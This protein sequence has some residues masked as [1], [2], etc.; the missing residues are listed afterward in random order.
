[1]GVAEN[2]LLQPERNDVKDEPYYYVRR[3]CCQKIRSNG[4][5][6]KAEITE[7]WL[8][9]RFILQAQTSVTFRLYT[10]CSGRS[11]RFGIVQCR[12]S[13]LKVIMYPNMDVDQKKISITSRCRLRTG[14]YVAV[15]PQIEVCIMNNPQR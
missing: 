2:L 13:D 3:E 10:P 9:L 15:G 1:M 14:W 4:A 5:L 6:V 7:E 12:V 11:R 8:F